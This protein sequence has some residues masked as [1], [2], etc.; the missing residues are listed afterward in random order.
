MVTFGC[1]W[2]TT[3]VQG[4]PGERLLQPT[5]AGL[6]ILY[7]Q[8]CVQRV[9]LL[10]R[11]IQNRPVGVTCHGMRPTFQLSVRLKD[12]SSFIMC[13]LTVVSC[14]VHFGVLNSSKAHASGYDR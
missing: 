2:L 7:L 4:F 11:R 9:T 1:S 10:T 6:T 14:D 13:R 5:G 8:I 3:K 12:H